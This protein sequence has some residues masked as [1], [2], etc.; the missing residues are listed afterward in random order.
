M[1]AVFRC[2][3]FQTPAWCARMC[4][5]IDHGRLSAAEIYDGDYRV[6]DDVRRTFEADVDAAVVREVEDAIAAVRPQVSR[7]FGTP[8]VGAEGPG[9][10]RYRQ[11]GFY[12]PHRDSL[13]DADDRFPRRVSLVL[14]LS[15]CEGGTL[16]VWDDAEEGPIDIAPVPNTLVAFPATWLHEVLPV[17]AGVRDVIVD[18]LY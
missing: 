5:A 17:T 4:A 13:A 8:L 18:W 15:A 7:F 9:F 10:L 11:G 2:P 1:S 14:F 6:D 12:A 3:Q 16:R